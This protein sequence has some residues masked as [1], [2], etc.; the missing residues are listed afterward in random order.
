MDYIALIGIAVGLSMDAFAVSLTNG[1]ANPKMRFELATKIAGTFAVFQAVMPF[2]GWCIGKAGEGIISA[3][4]HWIAL[5]LLLFLGGKMIWE[6]RKKEN[7]EASQQTDIPWKTLLLSG[8]ATSIDA[9]ATGVIL[10]SAV[11]ASSLPLI[12]L[13]VFIIGSVTFCL[14][15]P[16]V[17]IGK[18]FGN[19]LSSKAEIL[20]G[21]VLIA[22]GIKIFI[23]HQFFS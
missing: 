20:G 12:L 10:P 22:I 11:G 5:V 17:M 4:D 23:E 19:L 2:L 9:L 14:C 6:S 15:L 13:A 21:L 18:R 8:V 3:V 7:V 1:A 16:G